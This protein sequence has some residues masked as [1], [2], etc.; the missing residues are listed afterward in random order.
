[1]MLPLT[2][3]PRRQ[4]VLA[5]IMKAFSLA[6][7]RILAKPKSES[8][9]PNCTRTNYGAIEFLVTER[10][11]GRFPN[12]PLW[13]RSTWTKKQKRSL[14]SAGIESHLDIAKVGTES[15]IDSR[16]YMH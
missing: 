15:Y 2:S 4:A 13:S 14:D 9:F 16:E 3:R 12:H 11:F 10:L 6:G 5:S 1:M 8:G 7:F